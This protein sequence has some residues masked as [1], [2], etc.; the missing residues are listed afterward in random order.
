MIVSEAELIELSLVAVPAFADARITQ[1][2]ASEPDEATEPQPQDTPEEEQVSEP[3][4]VEASAAE[5]VPTTPI[6]AQAKPEFKLPSA[7]EY[8]SKMLQC[9]AEFAEVNQRL[10]A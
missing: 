5:I 3:E 7:A 1:I 4:K 9:G 2:A 10:R 6:Y 8:I